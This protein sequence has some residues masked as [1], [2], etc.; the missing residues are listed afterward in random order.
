MVRI[1]MF[2]TALFF[3]SCSSS[4]R[5][6]EKGW[7]EDRNKQFLKDCIANVNSAQVKGEEFCRCMLNTLSKKY[8]YEEAEQLSQD[9]LAPLANR[10]F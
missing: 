2:T 10:C 1:L 7:T 3:F 9:E 6:A 4:K 5:M 8:D